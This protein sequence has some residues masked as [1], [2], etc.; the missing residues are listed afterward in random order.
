MAVIENHNGDSLANMYSNARNSYYAIS[1]YPTTKFDGIITHVGG[2]G[3]SL[4]ATFLA[5]INQRNAVLSNFTVD[6]QFEHLTG[7]N[8]HA[9]A[10]I[11]KVAP[12][13]G[14]NLKLRV[15]VTESNLDINWGLGPDVNS[16]NRLMV[17]NANG[18]TLDFSS[19]DVQTVELDFVMSSAWASENCEL[20]AFVQDDSSKEILQADLK[21][22]AIPDYAL[23]AELA[24]VMNI[25]DKICNGEITPTVKLKNKGAEVLTSVNIN[26][27]INGTL[28]YTHPWTGE[29]VFPQGIEVDIPEISFAA[30]PENTIHVFLSDPNNQ[31]DMNPD[32][33]AII[34]QTTAT[35]VCTDYVALLLKTDA[36]PMHTSWECLG[37]NGDVLGSGGPYT[38]AYQYIKDTVFF[39]TP[40]C[41]QFFVYDSGGDGLAT[42]YSLRS[43]VNGVLVTIKSGGS[44]AYVDETQFTALAEGVAAAFSSSATSGCQMFSVDYTDMS[45]GTVT[46]WNWTFEGGTPATSTQQ[47]PTVSY[48]NAGTFDV[49]LTVSDGTHNNTFNAPNYITVY[50][51]PEVTLQELGDQCVYYPAFELNQGMPAGGV[52]SGTGVAN[53]WFDPAVAG[54][55]THIVTYTY[56]DAHGC[57]NFAERQVMV[58]ECVGIGDNPQATAM[59]IYPNPVTGT[60]TI[61][62]GLSQ[63]THVTAEIYN[64]I[65][66]LV[67]KLNDGVIEAGAHKISVN[68]SA[69]Q[70]GMYFVQFKAGETVITKKLTLV[71]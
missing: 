8:Y 17:P 57:E 50:E 55:G 11:T 20:I 10:V 71:K 23:D 4:Y 39:T 1:G 49:S 66:M 15:T 32:N 62:F 45:Y 36:N 52:Y 44:F 35:D 13:S 12:Y 56:S 70:N 64:S 68:M 41:Y 40:G 48:T 33:D 69:L 54:I 67:M 37:P 58:D 7:N 14:T 61:A 53:G 6:L 46:S 5:K 47:N 51:L 29:L 2:G 21:S 26:F 3:S 24:G 59:R 42:Y 43:Y 63:T 34:I 19:G 30:Q 28:L 22:M 16:V 31:P 25:P 38:Q 9:T 18:V 27:E 60:A 65:G